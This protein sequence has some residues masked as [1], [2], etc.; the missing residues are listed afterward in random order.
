MSDVINYLTNNGKIDTIETYLEKEL[1]KSNPEEIKKTIE[2]IY[3]YFEEYSGKEKKDSDITRIIKQQVK[4]GQI[5]I[6]EDGN[7]YFKVKK[8]KEKEIK[9]NN[10]NY[11][12][13]IIN[14]KSEQDSKQTKKEKGMEN[15]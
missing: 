3:K 14:I 6:N 9:L 5:Y 8:E 7:V 12:E 4:E 13:I 10:S 11:K 2:K 1:N 15:K